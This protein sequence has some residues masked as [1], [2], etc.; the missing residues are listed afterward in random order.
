MKKIFVSS[1]ILLGVLLANN[2]LT[3]GEKNPGVEMNPAGLINKQPVY[4][5]RL[6]NTTTSS[7]YIVAKDEYG[8]VLHEETISG[9][10]IIRNYQLNIQELGNTQVVFEV[11]NS[12]GMVIG[13][14]KV[15]G[16]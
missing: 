7:Y 4:Q 12:Y 1:A 5:L 15:S 9:T 13:T 16:K 2:T 11:Y 6:N 14:F 10:N 8:E 3:A